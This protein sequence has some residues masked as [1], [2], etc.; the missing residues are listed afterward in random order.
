MQAVKQLEEEIWAGLSGP[1]QSPLMNC[2]DS[3]PEKLLQIWSA[4]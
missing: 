4:S 1:G 3:A 2:A